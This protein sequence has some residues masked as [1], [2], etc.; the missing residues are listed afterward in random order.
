[1]TDERLARL[2]AHDRNIGRYRRLLKTNLSDIER[3]F[4]EQRLSEEKSAV[5]SLAHPAFHP[6]TE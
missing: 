1:M 3:Q 5:E 4:L 6:G 2:R